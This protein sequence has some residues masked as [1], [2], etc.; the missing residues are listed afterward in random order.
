MY[1]AHG[2]PAEEVVRERDAMLALDTL[3]KLI[4]QGELC[5]VPT[6]DGEMKNIYWALFDIAGG[7]EGLRALVEHRDSTVAD[8]AANTLAMVSPSLVTPLQA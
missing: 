1:R 4:Q 7:D 5:K 6:D 8:A 3:W 2:R